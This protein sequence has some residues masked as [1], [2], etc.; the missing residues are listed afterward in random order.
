MSVF[1]FISH[2]T[3]L[4]ASTSTTL[5][6]LISYHFYLGLQIKRPTVND[7]ASREVVDVMA[8]ECMDKYGFSS[9]LSFDEMSAALSREDI[10]FEVLQAWM[11]RFF[12]QEADTQPNRKGQLHLTKGGLKKKDIWDMYCQVLLPF[13]FVL[14]VYIFVC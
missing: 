4:L 10:D 8:A 7:P 5:H 2:N 13:F 14:C 6:L 12:K 1:L 11:D 3:L 9:P